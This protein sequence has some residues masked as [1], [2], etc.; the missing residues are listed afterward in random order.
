MPPSTPGQSEAAK[1]QAASSVGPSSASIQDVQAWMSG[2]RLHGDVKLWAHL[3]PG[4]YTCKVCG[5]SERRG[6]SKL[7]WGICPGQAVSTEPPV[8]KNQ[9]AAICSFRRRSSENLA[10]QLHAWFGSGEGRCSADDGGEGD[11][12]NEGDEGI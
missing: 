7:K 10:K 4:K 12:G 11:E 9:C 8:R 5:L 6:Q 3:T 1:P 2:L